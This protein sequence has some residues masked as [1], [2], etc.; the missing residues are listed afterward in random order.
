M[1]AEIYAWKAAD[2]D[3]PRAAAVQLKNRDQ[4]ISAFSRGLSALAFDSDASGNGT[5]LLGHWDETFSYD[6]PYV[7]PTSI[8]HS[9]DR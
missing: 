4:F 3:R 1:P 6:G 2:H 9:E 5:F 8:L 7:D